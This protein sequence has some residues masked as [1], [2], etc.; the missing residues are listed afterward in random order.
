ML[1][2]GGD[3]ALGDPGLAQE[4]G[5]DPLA[6]LRRFAAAAARGGAAGPPTSLVVDDSAF[7][8]TSTHPTWEPAD[9]PKWYAA[10]VGGLNFNDNCVEFTVSPAG[11]GQPA[12]FEVFPPNGWIEVENRCT[13][14]AKK[15]WILRDP[16]PLTTRSEA[17]TR[18]PI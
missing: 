18:G 12:R 10:P 2:G 13:T 11:T 8:A 1:R 17:R 3:P 9:L 6:V 5:G 14:G 7:E 4:R 15:P 16:A